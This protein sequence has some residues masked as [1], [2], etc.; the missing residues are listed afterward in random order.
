MHGHLQ[1]KLDSIAVMKCMGARSAQVIR[2]Y[3]AQTLMLG[4]GGG[5]IGVA[6]GI[7]VAAAFPGFIAKYFQIDTAAYW[8]SWP[9]AQG[10]AV[11]CLITLLFTL[12]PLLSIRTIRPAQV[13][14]RDVEAAPSAG[15]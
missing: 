9:A 8:D 12:P 13:F 4:L 14:R 1:Q 5:L 10:L 6:F 11:A 15:R 2:I 7:A 3:T